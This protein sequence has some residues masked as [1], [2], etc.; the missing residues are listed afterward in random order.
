MLDL[1]AGPGSKT[2]HLAELME[3]RGKIVACDIDEKRLRPLSETCVRLGIDI[4]G[5]V[6]LKEGTEPPPGPFDAALVDVPCSNTGV[7][8]RRPELRWRLKP[9]DLG[10]LVELQ[11]R[12]LTQAVERVKPGGVV[13]YSTCSVEPEE[14]RG[15]VD[16]VR[17]KVPDLT[18]EAEK[19]N[20]PGR[21]ADGGYWAK[22]R[23]P[24]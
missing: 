3:N 16:A 6:I 10:R 4:V 18:V 20:L 5:G 7:L 9:G 24:R 15:V 19:E 14:S 23:K 11:T 17:A 8:G 2:T 1:C 21:P 22:L 13:V 12:L